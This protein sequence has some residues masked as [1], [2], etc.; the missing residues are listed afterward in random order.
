MSALALKLWEMGEALETRLEK[1][2]D[3]LDL[4]VMALGKGEDTAELWDKLHEAAARN[5]QVA[6]L[7]AA[8]ETL[9]ADK[10]V[11][12]MQPDHQAHLHLRAAWFLAEVLRERT[13]AVLSAERAV[14]AVPGHPEAF[15]LL[16]DLLK[17]PEG[18]PRLARHYYEAS[19][20]GGVSDSR[21]PLLRRA[22]ELLAGD[23]ASGDL[24][25]E[26]ELQIFGLDPSDSRV[27]DDL[28]QRLIARGRHQQVVEILEASL[29]R[30][31]PPGPEESQLLREQA[32][33][34]SLGVLRDPQRALAH[35]EGLLVLEPSHVHARKLAEELVE[36][37]QLGL[38]AAAALSTAYERTGEIERAVEMLNF[39][40]KQ[41]RGPR[42]VEVQRKLGILRQDVLADPAG[43]LELLGPVVAGDPGDDD[44]RRRFV[45]LSFE[46]D[47]SAQAARLLSRALQTSRDPAVRTRVATDVGE[48]YL[49]TGDPKRA[50]GAFQQA[51]EL[52]ADDGATLRAAQQLAELYDEA[53]EPAQLAAALEIVTKLEP[54]RE[55]KQASARRLA[56]LVEQQ[57]GEA[58]RAA[59][60]WRALVG[61]PWN[62]EALDRLQKIYEESGDEEGLA[63][64]LHLRAESAKDPAEA[65]EL[66][67]RAAE[68]RS[69]RPR[70][71]AGAIDAWR[72]LAERYG[73][74]AE[75]DDR[76]LPLLEAEGRFPE[77]A[78][79]LER[80]AQ[81]VPEG[82]RIPLLVKIGQLRL[83]HLGDP[84]GALAAF[85]EVLKVQPDEPTSRAALEWLLGTGEVRLAAADVLEP[86]YRAEGAHAGIVRVLEARAEVGAGPEIFEAL[87]EALA[88][89]E[90]KLESPDKALELAGWGLEQAV[91]LG[92]DVPGWLAHVERIGAGGASQ[93]RAVFLADALAQRNVDTPE[94]FEL[95]CAAGAALAQ[96]G[97][98]PRAIETYR[99][100]LVFAPSSRELVSKVDELLAQQGA[101][102]QRLGLYVS[103]LGEETEPARRRELLH[104]IATLQGRELGDQEAAIA[105]WRTAI[106]AD[107][108]DT[109]AHDALVALLSDR[110]D[111]NGLYEELGRALPDAEG[112]RRSV[113]LLRLGE[114][115]AL[116][117]DSNRALEHYRE[118]MKEADLSADVL[119]V[120]EHLARECGD[121]ATA[122]AVLERRLAHTAEPAARGA[123]LERL[124]NVL[125]WLLDDR[126]SA[127]RV[128]LE[129]ARLCEAPGG[130]RERARQLYERVLD[131]DPSSR[132]AA[133][134]LAE[135]LAEAGDWERLEEVF[136][137]LVGL[138]GERDVIMLLV[139]LEERA[140][141]GQRFDAYT[142]LLDAGIA[143]VG[144]SRA[145]HLLLAKA[146]A[147]GAS[148]GREDE[149]VA[150]YRSLLERAGDDALTDAEAFSHF[151][152]S[153]PLTPARATDIRWLFEWR[154][155]RT[156]SPIDV[157]GEWAVVEE[158]RLGNRQAA[159]DLYTR[160]VEVD[161]ERIDAWSEIARLELALGRMDRASVA[162]EAL[163]ARTHGEAS[164]AAAVKLAA[165]LVTSLG[166]PAEALEAVAPVLEANP[167][168]LE[169]LRIVH[170]AFE[171][172][173]CRPRAAAL[174]ERIA[175]ASDGRTQRAEVIE[176]LLAV[177]AE[178]PEL[179]KARTRWL[180]QLLQTRRDN[181]AE[182]Q[183]LALQGAE[184]APEETELWDI[185]H[186]TARKLGDPAPI[187]EAY[188]RA[189]ERSL[190]PDV[191]DAMGLRMVEFLEEWFDD[192]DRVMRVLERVLA[193]SPAAEWA[194]DRL[195]LTFNSAGRWPELFQLYDRRLTA[196][197]APGEEAALLRE[198]SM[199]AKD[200]AGDAER[201]MGYLERLNRLAPGDGRVESTLERL[202]ERHGRTRPLIDLL[203]ARLASIA[204][205]ERGELS[206][207]IAALWLDLG[208]TPPAFQLAAGLLEAGSNELAAVALLERILSLPASREQLAGEDGPSVL[209]SS[210]RL[211]EKRYRAQKNT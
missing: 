83:S 115:A 186:E 156:A 63:D 108:K 54:A 177:S 195:K 165:I 101:P 18:A 53:R 98:L 182:A 65:R 209:E 137:V 89:A 114:V 204:A 24:A 107:P 200:F 161:P 141:A 16:E 97:D 152:H 164:H 118:L 37:R 122:R 47:Q 110:A 34:I 7:A 2:S 45:T 58:A 51:I 5:E 143:R 76:V 92:G 22:A 66:L 135:L 169:A 81:A 25:V 113:M 180:T 197:L 208:E 120:V 86:L 194:F 44:I 27:R 205:A 21:L 155:A 75:I 166:R 8:Y 173:E 71:R 46:L 74:S 187:A 140:I 162:L 6:E 104:A 68:M 96:A 35:V 72:A 90:S 48:V 64:V 33:D 88:I 144:A 125:A 157:L 112:E 85:S 154:L 190:P 198:A 119:D 149:A 111:W 168:D 80:R 42:R 69:R 14:A 153:A 15:A 12:L 130:D 145:R 60:A 50:Q 32:M 17:G 170:R 183:A 188:E 20:R 179:A 99:R 11:K 129:G 133:E 102:E 196:G 57:P 78:A 184:A 70:D 26:I 52:G 158:T 36:H 9:A 43:A 4:L 139:G 189:L 206:A 3:V 41:V 84:R 1:P 67:F 191:A 39:E 55:A 147:L 146:R 28:M 73:E 192:P 127:A 93:W 38:R 178:A 30:E 100:A 201:A 117:G 128:W 29:K 167:G 131:A 175:Q 176:A 13:G 59:T 61:S 31:P 79:A 151:L 174:L 211:L 160:L 142:R 121:G 95:A 185:A 23:E 56:R 10:R 105:T 91:A 94:L 87:G 123:L 124:G 203:T 132:E 116:R 138:A 159:A 126:A 106:T 171:V 193:L 199:A 77:V 134:R 202:Y 150:L 49:R 210:A 19:T 40:L 136:S 207:R 148:E 163:K 82:E 109:S 103:A 172:P 181:P 62:A